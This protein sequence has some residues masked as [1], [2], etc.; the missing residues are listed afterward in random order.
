MKVLFHGNNLS[1]QSYAGGIQ[2]RMRKIA[3]NLVQRGCQVDFFNPTKTKIKDYDVI[4]FFNLVPEHYDMVRFAHSYGVKVVISTIVPLK[5]PWKIRLITKLIR[6]PMMTI[7][8][9]NKSILDM[10]TAVIVESDTEKSFIINNYGTDKRKIHVIPNGTDIN[11]CN[12]DEIFKK[13]GFKRDFILCVGRF[14]NNK[15]QLSVIK[16]LKNEKVDVVFI[17][18]APSNNDA[19]YNKCVKEAKGHDNIHFMGWVD[20]NSSLLSSAYA[21]AKVYIFPSFQET[22]GM[23]LIEAGICG[24]NLVISNTLP[25]LDYPAFANCLTFCPNDVKDIKQKTLLAYNT[26]KDPSFKDMMIRCF[27]WDTVINEHIKLYSE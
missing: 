19:Y 5:N 21:N 15:N 1:F 16:A 6:H 27:S 7:Y 25:I 23:V 24:A 14:D 26:P 17:G 10:S 3:E 8:N 11:C 13:L 4:H 9:K 2:V 18:G 12:T 20:N 22:F